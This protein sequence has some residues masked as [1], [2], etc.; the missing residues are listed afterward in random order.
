MVNAQVPW[1]GVVELRYAD[2]NVLITS[3]LLISTVWLHLI[4]SDW[5]DLS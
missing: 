5:L 4:K 3:I 2:L 1:I